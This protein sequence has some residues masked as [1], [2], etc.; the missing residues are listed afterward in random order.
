MNFWSGKSVIVCGGSSGLGLSVAKQLV[1]QRAAQVTL[2]AR[3]TQRLREAVGKLNAL[4]VE[5]GATQVKV[6]AQAA[7][8]VDRQAAANLASTLSAEMPK[9]DLVVQ[10]VGQSDRGNVADLTRERLVELMDANVVSS[11]H[12]IQAFRSG[13]AAGG[14]VVV[15]IGSLSSLFAPRFLGGYSI[16]K[17]SLTALAQQARLEL[18]SEGIHVM[19]CCPGPIARPDAGHRYDHLAQQASG[20]PEQARRPGGGAKIKGLDPD[21]LSDQILRGAA[22]RRPLIILPRKVWWLRLVSSLSTSL[23]D[24][25]LLSRTS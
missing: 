16:A 8:L 18:A 14:G 15:L 22:S 10:A 24:R 2:V 4:A 25:I 9:I 3:D 21:W 12:A 6:S 20:M 23:G 5:I 11:L 19:L 1:R 13:L 7:N 17:H